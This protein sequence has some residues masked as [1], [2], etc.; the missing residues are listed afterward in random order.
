MNP[1]L[2]TAL[3]AGRNLLEHEAWT[4]L[5]RYGIPV[6]CHAFARNREEALQ[7]AEAVGFPLVL[8]IVS[9][10]ILH[11][12]DTGGVMVGILSPEQLA[13][14]YDK[15]LRAI[16]NALPDAEIAG[17]LLVRQAEKSVEYI[18]GMT[19]DEQFGPVLMF[20]LGGTL[21][22]LFGETSICLL[23]I[24]H[25]EALRMIR[26]SKAGTLLSGYRGDTPKDIEAAANL[27]VQLGRLTEENPEIKEIDL[28]PVFV[29]ENGL[30]PLD[31]RILTL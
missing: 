3:N 24:D 1:L 15:M 14:S 7:K 5:Q 10:D 12:S 4:L 26:E 8:K 28:N 9:K 22:E 18:A 23:P 11:K 19:R 31:A 30:L 17:V 6:P 21:V 20:G 27:L 2:R 25:D 16:G 13:D 29:Y